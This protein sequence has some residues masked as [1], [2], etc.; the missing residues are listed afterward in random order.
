LKFQ[1]DL[2]LVI[3]GTFFAGVQL[4]T[5]ALR[6]QVRIVSG[7][8]DIV[9]RGT[10]NQQYGVL[11]YAGNYIHSGTGTIEM[12]GD[13]FAGSPMGIRLNL[14]GGNVM[15]SFIISE[16]TSKPCHQDVGE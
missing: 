12:V 13:T 10:S 6:D 16:A 11:G 14:S 4:G 2:H 8:G 7:G 3:N 5:S 15:G 9:M 1:P